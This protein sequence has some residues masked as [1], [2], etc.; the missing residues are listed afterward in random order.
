MDCSGRRNRFQP[1]YYF[2][3]H[4]GNSWVFNGEIYKM[5]ITDITKHVGDKILTFTYYDSLDV[6]LWSEKYSLLKNQ[7]FLQSFEPATKLLPTVTFEPA[8]PFAPPSRKLG[9]KSSYEC[10]ETHTL[11]T[12]V[13]TNPVHIDYVVEAVEDVRVPAGTFLNC[14][15]MKISIKYPQSVKRPYFIGDQYWWFA[16]LVGPVKYDLPSA[17][18]ELVELPKSRGLQFEPPGS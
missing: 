9:Y 15:K 2:P 7:I 1:T 10:L 17:V 16:P 3:I 6:E 5:E 4:E 14:I 12:L 18:G 8:L 11:D 13:T